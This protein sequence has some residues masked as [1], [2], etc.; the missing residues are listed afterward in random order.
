MWSYYGAK[1]NI[2]GLYPPPKHG[3]IIEPFA[4]TGR[5]ALKYWERDV[6]LMDKYDVIVKIW[7][8]LQSCS[9]DDLLA[10][11][12]F[13]KK[14]QYLDDLKFEC[15]E[16]K[17]LMGFLIGKGS[18]RPRK[19]ASNRMS[20]HRPNHANYHIQ[21]IAK[22]LHKIKHWTILEGDYRSLENKE[23]TWFIDPPY[24]KGGDSYVVNNKSI[25]YSELAVWCQE[26]KG[27]VIVCE[28]TSANWLPFKELKKQKGSVRTTTEVIW[29]NL[30]TS[31]DV[32]QSKLL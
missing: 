13:I 29:S 24:Y 14:G 5:Y 17:L 4:G 9:K 23:A 32:Y 11:P 31:Y 20:V 8:W 18:E 6:V 3:L 19:K 2:I 7:Q 16:A 12:R 10:M 21:Q 22:S 27:Q 26:R 1:G 25:D 15:E 28:N 30:P